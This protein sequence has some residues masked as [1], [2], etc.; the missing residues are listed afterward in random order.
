MPKVLPVW[1]ANKHW[2]PNMAGKQQQK[3]NSYDIDELAEALLKL[4]D[5]RDPHVSFVALMAIL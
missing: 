3:P 1:T 2:L 5:P 4:S